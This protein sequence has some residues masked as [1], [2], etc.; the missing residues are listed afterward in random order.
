MLM[1]FMD[2][3]FEHQG[4][5][6]VLDYKSNF[7]G[8]DDA[9]YHPEALQQ[10]MLDHRY[11]VQ[12]AVYSLALHR[13]LKSRLGAAYDPEKHWGGAIYYFIRGVTSP[14]HGVTVLRPPA[15][16]WASLEALV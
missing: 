14:D 4:R 7:L 6:W 1:G 9:A 2:L 5:F 13:L 12:A 10:A 15:G 11:D 3:V 8:S 16:A